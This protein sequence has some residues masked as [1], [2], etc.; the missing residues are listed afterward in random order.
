MATGDRGD[1]R[2]VLSLIDLTDDHYVVEQSLFRSRY[3]AY[4]SRGNLVLRSKKKRFKLKEEFPFWDANDQE[5]FR[6]KAEGI[7][8]HAGDYTII[9][10]ATDQPVA[11]LD[12]NW[13]LLTHK[14][15]IRSA[16]DERLLAKVESRGA[17]T[18]LAREYIPFGGLLPHKYTI[19]SADGR[20]IGRIEGQ[21][22]L[23]DRYDITIE[24]TGDVPREAVVAAAM[25]ID[26]L[27]GN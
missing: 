19:E 24:D 2:D 7:M 11:I 17:L 18:A 10:S 26:A 25:V 3:K 9:D 5:V 21:F 22:S 14:W 12:K 1:Y 16:T 15:K 23:R 8:D 6:V 4:D 13:T 20:L 27:E